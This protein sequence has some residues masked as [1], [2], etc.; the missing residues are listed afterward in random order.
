MINNIFLAIV[1]F[2]SQLALFSQ[3]KGVSPLST[4]NSQHS[5]NT[6][7]VVVGISNYQDP[8]IPDLRFADK[9]AEA[10]ANYLRSD[11]GGKLDGDHLKVLIN[12]NA[13][14]AQFAN[15]L[16]WLWEVCKEGDQAIIYFSGH[17]DVEKKSLT[18]PGFLLCWDA[19][20]RVY[21]AGGAF[22]LPML[23][24]VVSTLS[25]QNKAMVIVITDACHSGKLA[26]SEIYG[27]QLTGQNLARQ[28]ANEIKILSCQPNEYSIE[29]EQ[30]G[31]GRG[32]FSFNLIDGLYGL[33][34]GNKDLTVNLQEL[35]RYL[36]DHVTTEVAPL[37]QVPMIIGNRVTRLSSVDTKFLEKLSSGKINRS[38]IFSPVDSR[39]MEDKIVDAIDTSIQGLY[40]LFKMALQNK[41]LLLP[42]NACANSYYEKLIVEPKL[43]R[44]HASMTRNFA[45]A[46]QDDAQQTMNRWISIDDNQA[47]QIGAKVKNYNIPIR[48]FSD[49]VKSYPSC[50]ERAAELLGKDHYLYATLMARKYFFEGFLLANGNRNPSN[51]IGEKAIEKFKQSLQWQPEHPAVFWQMSQIY[52][53][54]LLHPDSMEL[55][56]KKAMEVYPRWIVPYTTL[57]FNFSQKYK[58]FEKA[59][60]YLDQAMNIDSNSS[61]VWN[62]MGVYHIWKKEYKKAEEAFIK[63]IQIDSMVS[64]VYNNLGFVYNNMGKY[65][66]GEKNLKKSIQLDSTNSLQ[67]NTLGFL[68]NNSRRY[69]EAEQVLLKAIQLN[70]NYIEAHVNL[71]VTYYFSGRDKEAEKEFLEV[72]QLDSTSV[73]AFS[74]L[75]N[76]YRKRS[77]YPEAEKYLRRA[78]QIDSNFFQ[79][80]ANLGLVYHKLRQWK[81]ASPFLQKAVNAM[82]KNELLQAVLG[83]V[84]AHLDFDLDK[85][86]SCFEKAIELDPEYPDTYRYY[87]NFSLRKNK[88]EAA[89]TYLE[90]GLEK[91]V[92]EEQFAYE[93]LQT[94]PDFEEM[95]KDLKWKT[96]MKKYFP[97]KIKD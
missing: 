17:G 37:V 18:Q 28:Y 62:V 8:G 57:A 27:A 42:L 86:Q 21:M 43:Q 71:G 91:G 66:L 33:A 58:S 16:D 78:I 3:S 92:G 88:T 35:S 70:S 76:I 65:D 56:A 52:S 73:Q 93:D 77:N 46:L 20:A 31:G 5:T 54:Q 81:E 63:S 85:A 48:V 75:G 19:P 72:I 97:E 24:E 14:M 89:W 69:P 10:F 36:E 7:A 23:Q 51:E 40:Q 55:F 4:N 64:D 84:Y 82:P 15:A 25:T 45:A 59:K 60:L 80:S 26:G 96:L 79:A 39:G 9:D 41:H 50:L 38:Q 2:G 83:D 44:L 30:W 47:V 32:A 6:Y 13:T 94:D 61:K 68:Y 95:R 49:R 90:K 29:G 34:D 22:A 67:Y 11:A 12:S 74:N 87:A 1:L 53:Y